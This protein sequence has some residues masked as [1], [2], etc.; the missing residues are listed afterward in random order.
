M[1]FLIFPNKFLN[2][3]G[4]ITK[5]K[6]YKIIIAINFIFIFISV[7]IHHI[8]IK[9]LCKNNENQFEKL[10]LEKVISNDGLNFFYLVDIDLVVFMIHWGFFVIY[11]Q[12]LNISE[13]FD[14]FNHIY[15]SFFTKSYFSFISISSPIILYIFYQSET[16]VELT[17]NNIFLY[18]MI[19][20][21][22][23]LVVDILVYIFYEFPLKKIFKTLILKREV[24]NKEYDLYGDE[25]SSIED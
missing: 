24:F 19:N 9:L 25:I 23:I 16:V 2:L 4:K 3:H 7:N 8:F 1:P 21:I 17:E 20:I 10:S 11:S 5:K 18:S 14:F 6:Y 13:L 15:W 22:I 12:K